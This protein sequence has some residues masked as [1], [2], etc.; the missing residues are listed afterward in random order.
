MKNLL[1][2]IKNL[3]K[4]GKAKSQIDSNRI[5]IETLGKDNQPAL[6][7]M[8]YGIEIDPIVSNVMCL[9]LSES[10]NEDS[11]I[12]IPVDI[13]RL[14]KAKIIIRDNSKMIFSIGNKEGGDFMVRFNELKTGFDQLKLSFNTF[15]SS[16]YNL[17]TH[18]SNIPGL[19]SSVPV[20]LGVT[21]TASINSAK[22]TEIEV[23]SV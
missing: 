8:P 14:I 20:P 21:S 17:H 9:L 3:I 23:P 15:V 19:P 5:Q 22:I 7:A 13:D 4:A 1:I 16:I 6:L 18:I 2:K 11:M 12:A 10:G